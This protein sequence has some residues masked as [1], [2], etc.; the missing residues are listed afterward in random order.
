MAGYYVFHIDV[1]REPN[2]GMKQLFSRM[3]YKTQSLASKAAKELLTN[4]YGDN[5]DHAEIHVMHYTSKDY[6][7]KNSVIYI[8]PKNYGNN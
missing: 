6:N 4:E 2:G 1:W 3:E 7:D 8:K 5:Y